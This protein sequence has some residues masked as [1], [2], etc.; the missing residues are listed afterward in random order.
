MV[1]QRQI[2]GLE[3]RF[4]TAIKEISDL[5]SGNREIKKEYVAVFIV[6]K[7]ILKELLQK[8]CKEFES[9]EQ[10]LEKNKENEKIVENYE[11]VLQ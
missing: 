4:N 2:N 3:R 6:C 5:L 7:E 10:N 1:T 8:Y 9:F 11:S